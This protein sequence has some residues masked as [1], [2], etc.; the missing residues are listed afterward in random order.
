MAGTQV[1]PCQQR[2]SG[3]GLEYNVFPPA[4]AGCHGI[5]QCLNRRFQVTPGKGEVSPYVLDHHMLARF[6]TLSYMIEQ[7]G[8]V[9]VGGAD[10]VSLAIDFCQCT[11][12]PAGDQSRL[13]GVGIVFVYPLSYSPSRLKSK[14]GIA[15]VVLNPG[16]QTAG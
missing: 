9:S 16:E 2:G 1:A 8:Q 7:G 12:L 10:L 3:R 14:I 15:T 5:F 4:P 6:G 13:A 11:V